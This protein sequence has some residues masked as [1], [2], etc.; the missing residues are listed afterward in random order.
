ML[1]FIEILVVV[2][3][4]VICRDVCFGPFLSKEVNQSLFKKWQKKLLILLDKFPEKILEE[5][6]VSVDKIRHHEVPAGK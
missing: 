2:A 4:T 3:T 6:Q 5:R 1:C